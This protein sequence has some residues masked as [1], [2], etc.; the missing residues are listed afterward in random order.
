MSAKGYPVHPVSVIV[1]VWNKQKKLLFTLKIQDSLNK[2]LLRMAHFS[3]SPIILSTFL[4]RLCKPISTV[5]Q[6]LV[7]GFSIKP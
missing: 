7:K 3:C 2:Q 6:N 4:A 1:C 5:L